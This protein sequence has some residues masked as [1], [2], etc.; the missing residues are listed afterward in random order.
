MFRR[1]AVFLLII[2][3]VIAVGYLSMRRADIPFDTLEG[4]YTSDQ[5]EF[6]TT[7]DGLKVHYRD[8]GL[9]AGNTLVLVHGFAAS[10]HT[11]E[12]WVARL[13]DDYRIISLDLPGFG[14]TRSPGTENMNLPY[15][16]DTVGEVTAKL[17]ADTFVLVG[18]SMGGATSWQ[19]ALENQDRLEGLVLVGASG[20]R[21]E[22][23]DENVPLVFKLL[24]NPVARALAKDLDLKSLIRDGLEDSFVD[25][26]LV[27][28]DMVARYANLARGP[29]HRG[30]ILALQAGGER[31]EASDSVLS[32]ITVPTLILQGE[33]DNL[34]AASGAQKFN[35]AI[36]GSELVL[37]EQVGH[38][39][40]EEVA[41]QSAVDLV[42]FLTRRVW[43]QD[44]PV[45]DDSALEAAEEQE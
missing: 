27:D 26:S 24:R 13:K 16:A 41:A 12:P 32:A 34:V 9:Q 33:Q 30:A 8:E 15:F 35:A 1:I 22:V 29:G 17:G 5:S 42:D 43:P 7:D 28:E 39:P 40:H 44:A 10:L 3:V 6:L 37:Y 31:L 19:F 11:W 36:S 2:F 4:L 23:E 45:N 18:S 38:L 25:T 21:D 14:L 20:W